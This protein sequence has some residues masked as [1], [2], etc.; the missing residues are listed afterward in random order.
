MIK[1]TIIIILILL[2]VITIYSYYCLS[3]KMINYE[4]K[5]LE[6][7]LNKEQHL[8]HVE[9]NIKMI[10]DCNEKNEKY[11]LAI[12]DISS[13]LLNLAKQSGTLIPTELVPNELASSENISSENISNEHILNKLISDEKKNLILNDLN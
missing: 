9:N 12:K 10:T 6:Y 1:I 13:I 5:R 3:I 7:I 4:R 2:L 8:T 11:Q